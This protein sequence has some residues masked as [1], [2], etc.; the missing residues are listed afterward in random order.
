M[1][2]S[3][4]AETKA[5]SDWLLLGVYMFLIGDTCGGKYGVHIIFVLLDV[6]T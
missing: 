4:N 3:G 1:L 6:S 5:V 2:A